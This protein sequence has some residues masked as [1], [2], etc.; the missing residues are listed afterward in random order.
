[1]KNQQVMEKRESTGEV[2][3]L[4][5]EYIENTYQELTSLNSGGESRVTLVKEKGSARIA[6]KKKVSAEGAWIYQ[7]IKELNHPNIVRIYEVC[8]NGD[9]SVIVEEFVSGET[10]EQKLR[11]GPLAKEQAIKYSIQILNALEQL[12]WRNI[13][14]RDITPANVLISSDDVVKLIDFGISRYRKQNRVK[15]TEIL[16]TVGYAAPEQFG[17][18]Q[19]DVSTDFY[20]LGVMLNVMVTGKLPGEMITKDRRLGKVVRT[21]IQI[22]PDKRY[23][24][25]RRMRQDL[26]GGFVFRNRD[27][28]LEDV[29]VFPGFRSDIIWRKVVASAAYVVMMVYSVIAVVDAVSNTKA[30]MLEF[31][32]LAMLWMV[33]F[34]GSNFGRWDQWLFPFSRFPKGIRISIRIAVCLLLFTYG[35]EIDSYVNHVILPPP[36]GG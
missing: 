22:D 11:E 32:S 29:S 14:H 3:R 34:V 15:D 27:E 26:R 28:D 35:M 30:L 31:C 24:T 36:V 21:C 6:V 33:F 4:H 8:S 12:H 5:A 23:K 1:M 16:G 7:N 10:L 18:Q 9:D 19:T 25:A 13:I 20:A 2:I 17:F